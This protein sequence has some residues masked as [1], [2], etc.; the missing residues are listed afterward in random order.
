MIELKY[1]SCETN[2]P[3]A[4][5]VVR[6]EEAHIE[7][8]VDEIVKFLIAVTFHPDNILKAFRECEVPGAKSEDGYC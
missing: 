4:E 7:D 8:T 6:F 3:S 2:L 5:V 1:V